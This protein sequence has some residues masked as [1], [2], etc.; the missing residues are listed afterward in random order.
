MHLAAASCATIKSMLLLLARFIPFPTARYSRAAILPNSRTKSG[1][2]EGRLDFRPG[3]AAYDHVLLAS[4]TIPVV[5]AVD[6]DR[7]AILTGLLDHVHGLLGVFGASDAA[8]PDVL[9]G[10]AVPAGRLPF[11]LPGSMDAVSRQDLA[12]PDVS[13][14]PLF[15]A[16]FSVSRL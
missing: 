15:S 14:D 7:P 8:V 6:L 11:D 9:T 1:S 2:D 13:A 3:D 4:H 10:N 16:G 5:M 12:A